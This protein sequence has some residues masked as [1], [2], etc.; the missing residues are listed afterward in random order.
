MKKKWVSMLL[1]TVTAVSLCGG[2]VMAAESPSGTDTV[3]ETGMKTETDTDTEEA[4]TAASLPE[5][6]TPAEADPEALPEKKAAD[7]VFMVDSTSS[8][9]P[10]INSVKSNLTSFVRYLEEKGVNLRMSVIEYKDITADAGVYISIRR[11]R[12]SG[13]SVR[14]P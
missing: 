12:Y 10:Y 5:S 13:N 3:S 11:W 7:I 14:R 6:D 8:M 1:M 4:Q 2:S 9:S